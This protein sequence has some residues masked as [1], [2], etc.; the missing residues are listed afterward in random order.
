M[1]LIL[2]RA[3][4]TVRWHK[5]LAQETATTDAQLLSM[6]ETVG[7][8]SSTFDMINYQEHV[9]VKSVTSISFNLHWQ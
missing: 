4:S 5:T 1:I 2:K 3:S 6:I 9:S 8:I 7:Y